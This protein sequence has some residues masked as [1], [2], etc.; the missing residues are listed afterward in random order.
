MTAEMCISCIMSRE[1]NII[2]SKIQLKSNT[3]WSTDHAIYTQHVSMF[4]VLYFWFIFLDISILSK[5]DCPSKVYVSRDYFLY[6]TEMLQVWAFSR[7]WCHLPF[8]TLRLRLCLHFHVHEGHGFTGKRK[9]S[10][11]LLASK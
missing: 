7:F 10:C 6:G 9:D 4:I 1:N 5:S 8:F 2:S 11:I 3:I